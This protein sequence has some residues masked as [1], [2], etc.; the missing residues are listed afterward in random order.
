MLENDTFELDGM[1]L[2]GTLTSDIFDTSKFY[3]K[4]TELKTSSN[5]IKVNHFLYILYP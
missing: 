5:S 2:D 3:T 1:Q 4:S